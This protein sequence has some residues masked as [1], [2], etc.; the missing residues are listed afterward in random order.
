V[1]VSLPENNEECERSEGVSRLPDSTI[2]FNPSDPESVDLILSQFGPE[3]AYEIAKVL[4][5]AADQ[6]MTSAVE[7]TSEY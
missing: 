4:R 5:L 1:G 2:S 7:D 3:G 6:D